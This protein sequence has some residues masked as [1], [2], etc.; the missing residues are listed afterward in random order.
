MDLLKSGTVVTNLSELS[1]ANNGVFP[2]TRVYET[3]DG[4]VLLR[5]HG[6]KEMPVWGSRYRIEAGDS[7]YNESR[8]DAEAFV[9]ARILALTEYVYRLQAK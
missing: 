2:F 1:K 8:A 6:N 4:T 3:I 9:R 7:S 5:A